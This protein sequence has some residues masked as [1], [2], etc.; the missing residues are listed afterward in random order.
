MTEPQPARITETLDVIRK[1]ATTAGAPPV[2]IR[3]VAV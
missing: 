1:S 3:G 2:P